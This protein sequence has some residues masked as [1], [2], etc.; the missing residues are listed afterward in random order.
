MNL[1][2]FSMCNIPLQAKVYEGNLPSPFL[3]LFLLSLIVFFIAKK[4]KQYMLDMNDNSK[5]FIRSTLLG[6]ICFIVPTIAF[7]TISLETNFGDSLFDPLNW[8][9][10]IPGA[11]FGAIAG[12][13]TVKK[14]EKKEDF[15]IKEPETLESKIKGLKNLLDEGLLTQEEF[16][17]QKKKI[18]NP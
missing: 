9:L 1:Y 7:D 12:I 2:V 17:E 14:E 18:L 13:I 3:M 6:W 16:D 8:L 11:L 4:G 10:A 15:L 5:I